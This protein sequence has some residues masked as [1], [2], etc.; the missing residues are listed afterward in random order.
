MW[1][2]GAQVWFIAGLLS[3]V[4]NGVQAKATILSYCSFPVFYKTILNAEENYQLLPSGGASIEYVPDQGISVKFSTNSL[5]L[6]PTTPQGPILQMEFTWNTTQQMLYYDLSNIDGA[7]FAENGMLLQP[8]T[9]ASSKYNT[10]LT[11]GCAANS[12]VCPSVY[13]VPDGNNTMVCGPSTDLTLSLCTS[14]PIPHWI[15]HLRP[16]QLP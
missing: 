12:T 10:C 6:N 7:P 14:I 9:D 3:W 15:R 2:P 8:S 16:G 1:L 11:V 5:V 13:T 4:T